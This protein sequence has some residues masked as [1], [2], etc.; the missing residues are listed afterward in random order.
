MANERMSEWRRRWLMVLVW[1]VLLA[2]LAAPAAMAA[3]EV[4]PTAGEAVELIEAGLVALAGLLGWAITD[5]IRKWAWLPE[6]DRSKIGGAAA[7]LVAAVVSVAS[8]F[9]V[10]WLGQWTG[11]LDTSGIWSVV[12]FA[13]PASKGW[14]EVTSWRKARG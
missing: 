5:A 12:V 6:Q 14:F 9:I 7:N 4:P 3:Q 1:L 13:W 10:G 8:G 2:V 11:L